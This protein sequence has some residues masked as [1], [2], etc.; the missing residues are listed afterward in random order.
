ML[1]LICWLLIFLVVWLLILMVVCVFVW[2]E[3][4]IFVIIEVILLFEGVIDCV[5]LVL[6]LIWNDICLL[7][8]KGLL[9]NVVFLNVFEICVCNCDIFFC[10]VVLLVF[11]SVLLFVWIDSFLIC[12]IVLFIFDRFD[13]VICE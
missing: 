5:V 3:I 4:L 13:L 12:D 7:L 8:N 11:V 1:S 6:G 10:S 2:V 9:V